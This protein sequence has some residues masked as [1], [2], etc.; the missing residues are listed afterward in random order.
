[1][2]NILQ[3]IIII[4]AMMTGTLRA[5]VTSPTFDPGWAAQFQAAIDNV[6][7]GNGLRGLSVAVTIP[8]QGTFIGVGGESSPGKPITPDMQF[9]IGSNSKLFTAVLVMKL[10]ELGILSLDDHLSDWLPSY[11]NIDGSATIRQCL[12]H[13]TGFFDYSDG[14]VNHLQTKVVYEPN[15]FYTPQDLLALVGPP[16][17]AVGE[18]YFYSSTNYILAALAIEVATGKTYL[19]NLHQYILDPLDMDSSF[20]AAYES[21]NGNVA[22]GWFQEDNYYIG[23][24]PPNSFS[25]YWSSG[26]LFSTAN[27]MVQ[28]FDHLWAGDIIS[29]SSLDQLVRFRKSI[30]LWPRH[31]IWILSGPARG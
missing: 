16:H 9:G 3:S 17:F 30:F 4:T 27:E 5:Q 11:I 26:A 15:I 7:T 29:Q 21:P 31:S 22:E 13:Q 8:G 10:Q 1:M 12:S 19:E 2:K 25:A 14:N 28:W 23:D 6:M 24:T 20:L 18:G